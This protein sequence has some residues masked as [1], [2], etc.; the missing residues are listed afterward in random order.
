ML[1]QKIISKT[2]DWIAKRGAVKTQ[3]GQLWYWDVNPQ[4]DKEFSWSFE[5]ER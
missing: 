1:A 4:N 3:K 5:D 2:K